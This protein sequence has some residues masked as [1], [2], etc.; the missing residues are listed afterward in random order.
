MIK[1]VLTILLV[2][3]IFIP[4]EGAFTMASTPAWLDNSDIMPKYVDNKYVKLES[5]DDQDFLMSPDW[6][7]SLILVE[8][9][10][11][12][13]TP[14][15]TLESAVKM[16]DHYQEMGVNG[17]WIPPIFAKCDNLASGHMINGYNNYGPETIDPSITGE[18]DYKEGWE[19]FGWFVYQ[20]H[21]RNIRVLLDVTGWGVDDDAPLIKQHPEFFGDPNRWGGLSI[22]WGSE[23][24]QKWHVEQLM[25][26]IR[27]TKVDGFRLDLEPDLTG[28]YM[29]SVLRKKALDE[30]Y[31]IAIVPEAQ[32][33]RLGAYD[34]E[35][36]GVGHYDVPHNNQKHT[37]YTDGTYNIVDG[38]KNGQGMG[39]QITQAI[40]EGGQFRF[41][42]F[43]I[44]EHD[45]G[46]TQ[47]NKNLITIGYQ[48]IFAP[49]IPLWFMGEEM[50]LNVN[51]QTM[52][53]YGKPSLSLLDNEQNR[54]FYETLKKY[55]RIRR[56]YSDIFEYYPINHRETNICKVDVGGLETLQ[57][58]ARYMGNRAVLVV[59][60]DNINNKTGVLKVAV[61]F[62]ETG[63]SSYTRY[64]VTDLMTNKIIATGTKSQVG[65]IDVKVPIGTIG[66]YL[67]EATG[68]IKTPAIVSHTDSKPSTTNSTDMISD[69]GIVSTSDTNSGSDSITESSSES[70]SE[71]NTASTIESSTKSNENTEKPQP[72]SGIGWIG[73]MI[74][75]GS[76]IFGAGGSLFAYSFWIKK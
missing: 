74:I 37:Y 40:G 58:Y 45:C 63:L 32:S 42:T 5:G 35:Q 47:V 49:F 28:F 17:I 51:N 16:L 22:D 24:W 73:L 27:I 30:G 76:T 6:V 34:F 4:V 33:E 43:D 25:K 72:S 13:A 69:S 64:T 71:S 38:I 62:N 20:A 53:F 44:S 36:F 61:P 31:K 41:Y 21:K 52:Y 50:G 60:N 11:E 48:A 19:M 9:R 65:I 55:I 54:A 59:P 2:L 68:K 57:A 29:Y 23:A 3:L 70:T 56:Q 66:T 1:K 75:L 14:E 46:D 67:V 7:K 26:I 12:T 15:G 18:S 10:I 39:N 8:M